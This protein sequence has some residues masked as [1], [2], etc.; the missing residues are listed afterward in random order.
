MLSPYISTGLPQ[1]ASR[2]LET[3][4]LCCFSEPLPRDEGVIHLANGTYRLDGGFSEEKV[5]CTNRLAVPY[6]ADAP[7]PE[8]WLSFLSELLDEEDIPTLQE[9][10]GYMLIP[11]TR[12]QRMMMLIG[13]GGEGKSR[14]GLVLRAIFGD[15]MNTSTLHKIE[16]SR[17]ARADLEF[18][19]V[20]LDDDLPMSAL[21]ETNNVKALV[22]NEDKTD[23]ERK[24]EQS[25]QRDIYAR[26]ICFGNGALKARNDSSYAFYRRQM[27][28]K[29]KPRPRDRVDDPFLADKLKSEAPGILL[30]AIEGL[31]RLVENEFHFTESEK[32]IWNREQALASGDSIMS[33]MTSDMVEYDSEAKVTTV[34]LYRAYERWCHSWSISPMSCTS[35]STEL[36]KRTAELQID[37]ENHVNQTQRGFRGI[38]LKSAE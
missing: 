30:W 38:A 35:F 6:D 24:G 15:N 22:T 8:R 36:G 3:I 33:F 25:V 32:A 5:F 11:S 9:Y 10:M 28:I 20:M 26:F 4:K 37:K 17:F 34:E 13:R 23:I 27:I 7:K 16:N 14:I 18:K 31:H 1:R 29:V 12:A 21:P 19:L 2:L